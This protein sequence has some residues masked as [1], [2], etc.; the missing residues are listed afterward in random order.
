MSMFSTDGKCHNAEPGTYGHECGKPATWLA[1]NSV[2]GFQSGF[3]GQCRQFGSERHQFD[4]FE[5]ICAE[6]PK[7]PRTVLK[8]ET[9]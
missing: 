4:R 7:A 6:T 5:R 9:P 1:T 3:C 2:S 8:G